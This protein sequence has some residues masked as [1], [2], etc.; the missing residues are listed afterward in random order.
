MTAQSLHIFLRLHRQFLVA[1]FRSDP[2]SREPGIGQK[3]CDK[4]S[5]ASNDFWAFLQNLIKILNWELV[6]MK[7]IGDPNTK[8]VQYLNGP[9]LTTLRNGSDFECHLNK[10]L[11]QIP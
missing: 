2:R 4:I 10:F 8:H 11:G 1:V 6:L 9:K 7:Y 5:C 3:Q